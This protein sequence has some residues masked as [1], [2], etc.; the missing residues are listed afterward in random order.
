MNIKT[1]IISKLAVCNLQKFWFFLYKLALKGMNIGNGDYPS[2]SGEMNSI[3]FLQK[4]HLINEEP[5]VFDV[6]ANIGEYTNAILKIIPNAKIHC[7]E[8]ASKTFEILKKTVN[9]EKVQFNNFGISNIPGKA[10]LFSDNQDSGLASLYN[11]NLD[12]INTKL[13]LQEKVKLDSIDNYCQ[14]NNIGHIDLLKMDIE[15]NELHA[16]HGAKHMLSSGNIEVIQIEFGGCNIDSRTY[17]LD[18]WSLLRQSFDVYR[19]L[20]DKPYKIANYENILEVFTT[21]NY[22][23]IKKHN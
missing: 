12:F 14:K 2:D 22:L 23:F 20:M 11:R 21:T 5:V 1:K 18:F 6:G 3:R 13:S 16:L 19:I 7:F 17:F 15:G 8:P 10:T 9:K 4:N